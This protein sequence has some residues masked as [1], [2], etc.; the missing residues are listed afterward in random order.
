MEV[1]P[2][3]DMFVWLQ[4]LDLLAKITANDKVAS[5]ADKY[6][7]IMHQDMVFNR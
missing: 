3:F 1:V 4:L 2:E 6:G 7:K 5:K